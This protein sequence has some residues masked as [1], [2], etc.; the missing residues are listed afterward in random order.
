MLPRHRRNGLAG[1]LRTALALVAACLA[2]IAIPRV[3]RATVFADDGEPDDGS[4][5]STAPTLSPSSFG[6]IVGLAAAQRDEKTMD[7]ESR[8]A[9]VERAAE[10]GSEDAW[11]L[12]ESAAGDNLGDDPDGALRVRLA[13][14]RALASDPRT[15]VARTALRPLL[16]N[17]VP[18]MRGVATA[19]AY[20][21]AYPY[22]PYPYP[23]YAPPTPKTT[24]RAD[25]ELARLVRETAALSMA[26]QKDFEPLLARARARE[27]VEGARAASM[28]LLA[29]PPP[30]LATLTARDGIVT[31][32]TVELLALLGDL[33][34][35]DVLLRVAQAK[36]EAAS[37]LAMVAL[38]RAGDGRVVAIANAVAKDADPRVRVAAAE[39]LAILGEPA[40]DAAI[41]A[42]ASDRKTDSEGRRLAVQYP[43]AALIETIVP[44]AEQGDVAAI[45]ALG[46]AGIDGVAPLA[47]LARL[48]GALGDEAAYA[49]AIDPISDAGAAIV[50]ILDGA[51]PA[52]KRRA[53]RAAAV[54][55]YRIGKA[56]G[57][58]RDVG[59]ELLSSKDDADRFV[60]ALLAGVVDASRARALLADGDVFE[61]RAAAVSLGAHPIADAAAVARAHLAASASSEDPEVVRALASVAARAVDGTAAH[62][63]PITTSTLAVWLAQ[64][65][66]A[67][68]L[69]AFLLAARG[70]DTAKPHVAR[71]LI[72]DDLS[73][74]S[75]ALLGLALS[76][77]ADA[78]G[79]LVTRLHDLVS[80][81]LRRAAVR[82]LV[83]RG[84][85]A[86]KHALAAAALLDPDEGTRALA[87]RAVL[88]PHP[89]PSTPLVAGSEVM[90]VHVVAPAGLGITAT[91]VEIDGMAPPAIAD[92]DGFVVVFRVPP[93]AARLDVRPVAIAAAA[94]SAKASA[95]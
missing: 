29:Y 17:P 89:T 93:G 16:T 6:G 45:A 87:A 32:E 69:A 33:R 66:D 9:A 38:A 12:V 35:D 48:D 58:L 79:E 83:A 86:G 64:D 54:R 91:L 50:A 59:D 47:A 90:Q 92:P 77:D 23:T 62:D 19:S 56:P 4:G 18:V 82:A 73:V 7:C 30:S 95:P 71:A 22:S 39:A 63:V 37:A 53:V 51:T 61:R 88:L 52:K 65:G 13:A 94:T 75:A 2:G 27:D 11:K 81:M 42:L 49:L 40:A 31:R 68:P 55:A 34:A 1:G 5:A 70:G 20:P 26:L 25:G 28:A 84:D 78:T 76:P 85:I 60:G 74:R 46:R 14:A 41:K 3:G 36:D 24:K 10:I 8:A 15:G 21:S 80:P 44:L 57:K 72:A 67:S 43:S